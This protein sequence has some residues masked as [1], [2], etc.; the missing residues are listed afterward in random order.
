MSLE[1]APNASPLALERLA[2]LKSALADMGSV[3]IA[4]SG[5]VDS[6]FLLAVAHQVLGDQVLAVTSAG[7]AAPARDIERTRAFCR[8]RS[9]RQVVVDYDELAIPEF[10]N[11][12]K[13]RCYHCKKAL[14]TQM[15]QAAAAQGITRLV[16]GSNKD[17]E[18]DYRPGMKALV[19]LGIGSPLREAGLTKAQ[20][21]ELSR[22]MG[23]P[24]WDMPSAACLASRF[25][26]GEH[27]TAEKLKRVE[28]A[29]DFLHD[30]GLAQVRVRVHGETGDLARIEVEEQDIARLAQQDLRHKLVDHLR[31]L[32]FT[33]VSLDLLGFRSGAMNESIGR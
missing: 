10:A 7:R 5:G 32:S 21:R 29:E 13:D 20:I 6:T 31:A 11:N 22:D 9:I 3:A 15:S 4:Y 33:Y 30:L 18:G 12:P 17:D 28:L 19:E 14:F 8:E 23:L 24:T 26:Y 1:S 25:V 16:D 2:A 27:I